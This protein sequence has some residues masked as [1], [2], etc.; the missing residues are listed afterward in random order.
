MS[1]ISHLFQTSNT[2]GFFI[3]GENPAGHLRAGLIG[4]KGANN[5]SAGISAQEV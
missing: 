5:R 1:E 3:L 4:T 2:A